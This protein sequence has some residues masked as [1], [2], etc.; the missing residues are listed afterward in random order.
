MSYVDKIFSYRYTCESCL[1]ELFPQAQIAYEQIKLTPICLAFSGALR[2]Q[3]F[4][5]VTVDSVYNG[6]WT[7]YNRYRHEAMANM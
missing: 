5:Q 6:D 1:L 2:E 4:A 7:Q 3:M